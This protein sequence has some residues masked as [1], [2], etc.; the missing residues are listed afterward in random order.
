MTLQVKDVMGLVAIAVRPE[1][2][3]AELVTTMRRYKVGAVAVIDEE[4]RPIGMVSEDDLLLIAVDAGV[5]RVR[6]RLA[7]RSQIARLV[8]AGRRIEGVIEVEV[9]IAYE[10]DDLA[11]TPPLRV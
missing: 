8:E 7:R 5:V 3:F 6:G 11:K 9:D 10:Q 2:T 4:G 1:A